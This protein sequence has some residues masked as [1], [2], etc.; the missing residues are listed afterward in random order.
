MRRRVHHGCMRGWAVVVFGL[1]VVGFGASGCKDKALEAKLAATEAKLAACDAR[2]AG[3]EAKL[4]EQERALAAGRG[5]AAPVTVTPPTPLELA[6][7]CRHLVG[8]GQ[9]VA[10]RI[11]S[12]RRV[13]NGAAPAGRID[14]RGPES[15]SARKRG[16]ADRKHDDAA[17]EHGTGRLLDP[18]PPT[19]TPR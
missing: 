1:A 6:H 5:A 18:E 14:G 2:S 9:R 11:L 12:L 17:R 13:G 4:A 8:R 7:P 10:H 3:L 19:H 15:P 16:G